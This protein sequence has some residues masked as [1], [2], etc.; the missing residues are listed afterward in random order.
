MVAIFNNNKKFISYSEDLSLNPNLKTFT[1]NILMREIP[2]DKEDL[3]IWRWEGDYDNGEMVLINDISYP[4]KK[5]DLDY[6][7][8][9]KIYEKYPIDLQNVIIIKQL[10]LLCDNVSNNI[11]T[12]DFK[13]MSDLLLKAV[14][15]Y[16]YDNKFYLKNDEK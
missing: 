6:S 14:E 13:E 4:T 1:Q 2:L 15:N 16:E 3:T 5:S 11:I 9:E 12:N 8:Y 7:L 10:K